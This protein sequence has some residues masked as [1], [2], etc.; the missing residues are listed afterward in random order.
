MDN[1]RPFFKDNI[2]NNGPEND[3]YW[4]D[5]TFKDSDFDVDESIIIGKHVKNEN[6]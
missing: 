6:N 5:D 4:E 2:D 1:I 3:G